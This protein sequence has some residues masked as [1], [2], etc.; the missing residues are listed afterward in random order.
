[1]TTGDDVNDMHDVDNDDDD[2]ETRKRI[3][4]EKEKKKIL[5]DHTDLFMLEHRFGASDG[6]Y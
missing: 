6:V 2:R 5:Q 4:V 3:N 1:M